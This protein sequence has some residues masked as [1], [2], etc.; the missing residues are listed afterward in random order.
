MGNIYI[1][2][3]THTHTQTKPTHIDT[4]N[5]IKVIGGEMGWEQAV[6]WEQGVNCM[7]MDGSQPF[8]GELTAVYTEVKI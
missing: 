8:G 6:K 5:R 7:K 2:T 3:H 4:E 1:H